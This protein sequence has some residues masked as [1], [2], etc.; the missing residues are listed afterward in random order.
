MDF[1]PAFFHPAA[2]GGS[3]DPRT[4]SVTIKGPGG[5]YVY[6]GK[7]ILAVNLALSTDR[8]LLVTGAPGSG[9]TALA[10]N[11]ARVQGWR[12][13]QKTITSRTQARDLQW[14][15]DPLR[16]LNDAQA[17]KRGQKLPSRAEYIE[18]E[19]MWWGFDPAT[20]K[21]R[22]AEASS[23][24][25]A[26]DPSPPS[27]SMNAVI[28][29]DEIDKAEPDVPNDLLEPLDVKRFWVE[30]LETT[31]LIAAKHTILLFVTTNGE[32]ELPPAFMRRC[33]V[34]NLPDPT[35]DWLV[36][37]ANQHLEVENEKFHREVATKVTMLMKAARARGER[38][39]STAEYLD[40][41]RA[42]RSLEIGVNSRWWSSVVDA[43]L[44]KREQPETVD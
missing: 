4:G 19:V 25:Q 36:G 43:L 32:R 40:A 17:A 41:L 21:W 30:D 22:G 34:L 27:E 10:A 9:K 3:V 28:L 11:V 37:V 6:S 20:A 8:P 2:R 35:E 29:L 12:Y 26:K 23:V 16:R 42:C 5:P 13:Y 38:L 1:T 15:F 24:S 44:W 14:R 18:P 39:P 7:I 33:V 31:T